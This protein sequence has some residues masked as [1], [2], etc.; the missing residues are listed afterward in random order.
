VAE[1][2]VESITGSLPDEAL[3]K[4]GPACL[5]ERLSKKSEVRSKKAEVK[6][7]RASRPLW[8]STGETPVPPNATLLQPSFSP[9]RFH[10]MPDQPA[11]D[12]I[13]MRK[14]H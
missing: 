14:S 3:A 7:N 5:R 6:T 11:C 4:S 8:S 12:W 9:C 13:Q 10:P 2:S 1:N